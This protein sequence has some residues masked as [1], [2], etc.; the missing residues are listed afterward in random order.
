[1]NKVRQ[2]LRR[3][4]PRGKGVVVALYGGFFAVLLA[5][6]A[7]GVGQYWDWTFPYYADQITNFFG[8]ASQSWTA[9]AGGSP[10]GYSSDY[11]VRWVISLFSWLQPEWLLYLLLLVL[12]VA[13]SFGVYLIARVHVKPAIAFLLGLAAFVNPTI[14]YKFTAGHID[15]MVS[16]VILIYLVYFLLYRFRPNMRSAILVGLLWALIGAQ[17]QFLAIAGGLIILYFIFQPDMWRWKFLAPL[18]LL[19]VLGNAVW[20]SNFIFAGADIASVSGEATKGSFRG[21]SSSDYLHIFSFSFSKATLITRF[22]GVY[23]LLLYGLIFVLMVAALLKS[24]RKQIEDAWLLTFLLVVLFFATGLFQLINLGPITTLYPMFREVGHFA[25]VIVLVVI[26]L[27]G[28][29]MPR[30]AVKGVVV[31]W[32]VLVVGLSFLRYQLNAQ[33]IDFAAVRDK[34]A[35]FKQFD[36]KHPDPGGRV[37]M[38]PFFGQYSFV[39]FPRQFQANLP[40][41]NSGHDGFTTYSDQEFIKNAVKPQDF[42]LSM[43]YQLLSTQNI[44][45]L[46]PYNIR[47]IYDF[48]HIYESFYDRYVPPSTYDGN[49]GWI[50]NNPN[51]MDQLLAANPGKLKR[52]SDH[53]LEVTNYTPRVTTGDALYAVNSKNDGEV[54]RLFMSTAF[55]ERSYDYIDRSTAARTPQNTGSVAPLLTNAQPDLIDMAGKSLTQTI[56]PEQGAV[57]KLYRTSQPSTVAYQAVNGTVVFYAGGTGKLYLNGQLI[58]DDQSAQPQIISQIKMAP[59]KEYFIALGGTIKPI[60]RNGAEVIGRLGNNQILELFAGAPNLISN[61]SFEA[62]LWGQ[63]VGDCND[64]D[65]QPDISMKQNAETASLGKK[66]LELRA[67][68]HNACTSTNFELKG[69]SL[70]LLGHD[71][72]SPNA[73]TASFYLRFNNSDKEGIKRY[74]A[75]SDDKWHSS[76]Y[77]IITPQ[78]ARSG[79]LFLHAMGSNKDQPAINRYDNIRLTELTKVGEF[80][81]T[82]AQKKYDSTELAAGKEATFHYVDPTYNYQNAVRNGSFEEGAWQEKTHDCNA[83]DAAPRIGMSLD[84][85]IKKHGSQSLKLEVTRHTACTFTNV[86][87]QPDTEYLLMFDYKAEGSG[88]LGYFAEFDG[89]DVGSQERITPKGKEWQTYATKIRS[90]YSS[91]LRLYLHAYETNGSTKQTVYFD[92][93]RLVAVPSVAQQFYVVGEPVAGITKPERLEYRTNSETNRTVKVTGAR[94]PFV[95]MLSESYHPSWLLRLPS[96]TADNWLAPGSIAE[97]GEQFRANSYA[98]GWLVDP[99]KICAGD[100]PSCHKNADGSYNIDL[101][102]EFTPQRWFEINR[103]V[104]VSTLVL[105]GGYIALTHRQAKRRYELEGVYRHPLAWRRHKRK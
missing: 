34:F 99:A 72:Q 58:Q 46:K 1:M 16:Y 20:L 56:R 54:A 51:F 67:K 12:F 95:V 4:V 8:R 14:F 40:M 28:R 81:I 84:K 102:A 76:Y 44:D 6:A 74:Q 87:I 93:V 57:T 17:I 5:Q 100:Q 97:A 38:Y 94:G 66:S 50:K 35:E 64:F 49:L 60:K 53:I 83:Y 104:S 3:I 15:Y 78:D 79:Q 32:L 59:D 55:P 70:Y 85:N 103:F 62:G 77:P 52:V 101:V 71:Y 10:L 33:S 26:L 105:A 18:L 69:N 82:A 24:K 92:N 86:P 96:A 27:L 31:V 68:R 37:L 23:E 19:P 65:D 89:A 22:Y 21:A 30:G 48:S 63:Q 43:Q 29:L 25:P 80:P 45:V 7:R 75:I 42:K 39:D 9:M 90:P 47:Y 13:G 11:F 41:R 2:V 61:A 91:S 36:D 88:Q 98:N 73:E